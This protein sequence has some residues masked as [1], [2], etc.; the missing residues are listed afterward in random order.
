MSKT[1][2][3]KVW[4]GAANRILNSLHFQENILNYFDDSITE[5]F[6][7]LYS[8]SGWFDSGVEL[9]ADGNDKFKLQNYAEPSG[10][11]YGR[12]LDLG[13]RTSDVEGIQFENSLGTDYDVACKRSTLPQ[14]IEVNPKDGQPNWLLLEDV[15]GVSGTPDSVDDNGDGTLTAVVDSI[16]ES[17]VSNA[18]RTVLIMQSVPAKGATSEAI[19]KEELTV[20]WDGS[21]NKITTSGDLGQDTISTT[22]SDYYIVMLGPR[23]MVS[24]SALQSATEYAYVGT[25]T[26][27]GSGNPPSTFDI[28]GQT[29]VTSS[30]SDLW[31]VLRKHN[32]P[33][34]RWKIDVKSIAAEENA[35][36]SQIRVTGWD[37]VGGQ[38]TVFDVDELGNVVIDGDLTVQGETTQ[39][40]VV[41]VN[42]DEII[43]DSLTVGDADGDSHLIKGTW[44]H[45]NA[46]ESETWLVVDSSNSGHVGIGIAADPTYCLNVGSGGAQVAG[47]ILPSGSHDLGA[48]GTRWDSVFCNTIDA[49]NFVVGGHFTP[50]ADDT[51]DLG[52]D[53]TPLEWRDLYLDGTA[54]ID[55]I[56]LS[57]AVGEGFNSNVE[58][59]AAD[60]YRLGSS[61]RWERVFAQIGAFEFATASGSG[62]AAYFEV[63]D[64][65]PSFRLKDADASGANDQKHWRIEC[66]TNGRI[67]FK[68]YDDAQT[69]S[70]TFLRADKNATS[71]L[72]DDVY[73]D[74]V[75]QLF[76]EGGSKVDIIAAD[77]GGHIEL[78]A[79]DYILLY[80]TAVASGVGQVQIQAD[81]VP[82]ANQAFSLG[83]ASLQWQYFHLSE[84][85]GEGCATD[86]LPS[87]DKTKKIGLYNTNTEVGYRWT[88]LNAINLLLASDAG[89]TDASLFLFHEGQSADEGMWAVKIDDSTNRLRI[90]ANQD[91]GTEGTVALDFVR[92][93]GDVCSRIECDVD[94]IS[95]SGSSA[96]VGT[97]TNPWDEMTS[98]QYNVSGSNA[99]Q[100]PIINF[101][102]SDGPTN[103]KYWELATLSNG[104]FVIRTLQ[105]DLSTGDLI[106]SI[107]R[108]GATAETIEL[109][110]DLEVVPETDGNVEFGTGLKRFNQ[111][112][113]SGQV[114]AQQFRATGDSGSG[115]SGSTI[116]TNGS[117]SGG[118]TDSEVHAGG[119]TNQG[120]IKV[121]VGTTVGY[122]PYWTTIT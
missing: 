101:R 13:E 86:F 95:A 108:S 88:I 121:Y 91:D 112:N 56:E 115:A 27:A 25:V 73:L 50:S 68:S 34:E 102:H 122:I 114:M 22:A 4:I 119:N 60:T 66:G 41:T 48:S 11:S 12:L 20:V 18:G 6:R 111:G 87:A 35:G 7:V 81:L 117:V 65:T 38:T 110:D 69:S 62:G 16:T 96:G 82:Q 26:G 100:Q 77:N 5:W 90:T 71:H 64:D 107:S 59:A 98:K 44:W 93:T 39:Q 70:S 94:F 75:D 47:D 78:T 84:K 33:P 3:Q 113:F 55:T 83:D 67:E 19:A 28:S 42:S 17:G 8:S 15:V 118:A 57:T 92:G 106:L 9:A 99:T 97:D 74:A 43:T 1:A 10:V 61:R 51:Y 49:S 21:N 53:S 58:P 120:F 46:A 30:T 85:N 36:I 45:R 52:E 32:V 79:E 105:D 40:D 2:D 23:V 80:A 72:V 31:Q 76:L 63:D 109:S 54:Y 37:G 103:E 89:T 104:L 116:F 14:D 24:P 29:I